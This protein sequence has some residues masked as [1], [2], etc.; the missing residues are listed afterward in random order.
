MTY[1]SAKK[2]YPGNWVEPLNGW[3]KNIDT[4]DNGSND[5]TKGGPTSVLAIPGYRY[6]Q[7]RGY[8]AVTATS[9]AGAV[10][11]AD[12][13]VPSPYQNDDTRTNITGMVISGSSTLP[14]YVYRTAISVASGWG[15]GRVA[16]GIYA[17]TGNVLSFGRS[18]AGS[19]TAASGVGE[20]VIQANLT[21]TVSGSQAGE[22]LFAAGVQGFGT[23]PFHI[24][25]GAA[26]VTAGNVNYAATASTTMKVFAK[27]TANSTATSGGFYISSG[28]SLA[29]RVGYF[30]V[31][32]CYIQPDEAP[33]YEDIDSYLIGRT[34]S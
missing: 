20:G 10:S 28:D 7:Q 6:F 25:S 9:G 3:Y 4:N 30:V 31:E 32:I 18:N 24:A 19:P 22:I 27:E 34:V 1:L 11:S 17:A 21:S 26:G 5:S 16:S 15:D 23:N 29:G 8:V 2:I 13:I 33:G 12:V 14:A